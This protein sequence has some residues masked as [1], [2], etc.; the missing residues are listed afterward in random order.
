MIKR[1]NDWVA[2]KIS[3]MFS[4]MG[5]FWAFCILALI[6]LVVPKL[7][8][9]VQFISSGFLQ[10][11]ALPLLAVAAKINNDQAKQHQQDLALLHEKHDALHE[12]VVQLAEDGN[13]GR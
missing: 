12:R 6:P 1:F 7:L 5:C 8:P 9:E 3:D 10:L 11:V 13:D 4:T 2:V